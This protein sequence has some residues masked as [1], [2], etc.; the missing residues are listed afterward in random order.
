MT[1]LTSV[2]LFDSASY[3]IAGV[4]IFLIS[5]IPEITPKKSEIIGAFTTWSSMWREW[6]SGI[7]I[8]TK[9]RPIA[10]VFI[11]VIIAMLGEGIIQALLVLFVKLLGGGAMEFGWLL[12]LRGLGGLLGGLIFGRIGTT[13]QPHR[14]FPWTLAGMGLLLLVMVNNPVLVLA[15]ILLCLI[16]IL[17]IGANVTSTTMLQNSAPNDYLGRIFGLLGMTSGLMILLGQGLASAF[18]DRLG[19]VVLLNIAAGLYFLSGLIP[20]VMLKNMPGSGNDK[21]EFGKI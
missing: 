9:S 18:A 14:I 3:L 10:V 1:G 7:K 2:V 6:A 19:V 15:L 20:L 17:A 4:M 21:T 8:S 12:I 11:A 5:W 13:V 16:G